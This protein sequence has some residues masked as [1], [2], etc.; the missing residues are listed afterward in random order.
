MR[1]T[2]FLL[3]LIG[4]MMVLG[5][6]GGQSVTSPDGK[7]RVTAHD[8]LLTVT[9]GGQLVSQIAVD[10]CVSG[11][12]SATRQVDIAYHMLTGKRAACSN[13]GR[14]RTI[15]FSDFALEMMVFAD[16]IAFRTTEAE[17]HEACQ[18][19]T[20]G[21]FTYL[22]PE[23]SNRWASRLKADY[24]NFFPR[25]TEAEPGE[26]AYPLLAEPADGLFTLFTEG[27]MTAGHGGS[28]LTVA[29]GSEGYVITTPRGEEVQPMPTTPQPWNIIVVGSLADIVESTLVTDVSE[30]CQMDDT[31]WIEPGT[32]AWIY[33][34]YNHGSRDYA[35]VTRY[36]DLAAEMGWKY[37]LIG[38]EWDVMQGG[39]MEEAVAY[40]RSKGIK[41]NLWYN[42]GTSWIGPWAPGPQDRL[43]TAEKR[44]EEMSRLEAIGVSG[45][46][47]DFFKDDSPAIMDYYVDILRDAARHHLLVDF[48]GCT[49]PRGWQRTW[50]NLMSMEAVYGAEWYNNR[51]DLTE[52]AAVH[53]ATLPF[54]RGVVGPMDYTP[55][56]FTDSQH[57]H[58]TTWTHELAL[59]I[60][61]ESGLQHMPDRPEAYLMLP[62]EVRA[63]LSGLPTAWDDTRLLGGY[64]GEYAIMARRKG[65]IWYIAGINGTNDGKTLTADLATLGINGTATI[66]LFTDASD[67]KGIV[68]QPADGTRLS[69]PCLPRGGFVATEKQLRLEN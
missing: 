10:G 39:T 23:G 43:L 4:A 13:H 9:Y 60:L 28:H 65:D 37:N 24:E 7:L 12:A 30:P 5:A 59:P 29:N 1:K 44:E 14:T 69:V 50:P 18:A 45:I 8:S 62:A 46:K 20:E 49:V 22:V 42:S 36:I 56:T 19:S 63:L 38:W 6:C 54:T 41:T 25:L 51:P 11:K 48:H 33:W 66:N 2:V 53:N 64:P 3:P 55:G 61:F 35:T 21:L 15:P 27:G 17:P 67:G 32:S 47:V 26:W 57:P 31:S 34:A 58:I 16:G 68:A 40:A 52:A